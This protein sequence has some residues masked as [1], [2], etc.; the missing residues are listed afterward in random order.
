MTDIGGTEA[1]A[2][3]FADEPEVTA[4]APGRVNLMGEHTDYHSGLV[5]PTV[6]P[7]RTRALLR[8]RT[9]GE[10]RAVSTGIPGTPLTFMIGQERLTAR[11]VDYVQ[12]ITAALARRGV[13][14]SGF[15]LLV[16]STIPIGAGVSSSA[17]LLVSVLRALRTAFALNLD[18]LAIATLAHTVETEFVG[19]PVG[20]MDPMVCSLGRMGEALF[21]DTGTLQYERMSLPTHLEVVVIDSGIAHRHTSGEYALRRQESFSAADA[22]GVQHLGQLGAEALGR[23]DSLEPLL[24]HRARHVIT[25]NQRVRDAVAAIHQGNLRR[26]GDLFNASHTSM[27]EEYEI[28]TP[29]ID[30]LVS[31]AQAHPDVY[32]ARM[33]G[34]GFG[35]AVVILAAHHRGRE[36]AAHV[37]TRYQHEGHT[38]GSVLMPSGVQVP[39]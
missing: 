34:G 16:S 26:L 33:T 38:N 18:D 25:E 31:L 6:L 1:F 27:R 8:R 2:R 7:L 24:A 30:R 23:L 29:E 32:G 3:F 21:I 36:V 15:D 10:A 39:D 35:G 28:T 14:V 20:I 19:V 13:S 5:L 17:A 37:L 4:E 12:G 9:G 22:L 11:W